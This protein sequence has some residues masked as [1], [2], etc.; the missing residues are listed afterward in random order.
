MSLANFDTALH[1]FA[2]NFDTEY[3]DKAV[4]TRG[5]F[6]CS[7]PLSKLK[8]IA[9]DDYVI[10]KGTASFCA[11]VE[12][13]TKAWANMQGATA[14]KFGIYFGKTKSDPTM[15]YRF[16]Q[17]FGKTEN[18]A[19]DGVKEALLNLVKAGKSKSFR[20]IDENPLSQ[21]FKA[22]IL[23]LYFP[24]IYLNIC[25]SEHLEKIALSIGISEQQFVSEY[26]HLLVENKLANKITKDW[27]NPKFMSFLYAN[28]IRGDLSTPPSAT[29]KNPRKKSRRR[30]NFEDITA[31]R[32]AI[33]KASEE[34]AIE[35]E[36]NRLIG[37]GYQ[38]LVTKIEDRRDIPSY[39]YDYLSFSAPGHER[40]IEVKSVGRDRE[41]ECFRFYLS[42]NELSVSNSDESSS[43]YYFYLVLYGKDGKPCDLL[44]RH[45]KEFYKS[46]EISPC[47]YVVRFDLEDHN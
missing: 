37:L 38:E 8:N 12:V 32:D 42:E 44:A 13:K 27:S 43:D 14:K 34:F 35:W 47:A 29:F 9:L 41:E 2:Q 33:G 1:A 24:E 31:N 4:I 10:G 15:R 16:A 26:Q 19:F 22:K 11:C 23:S 18:E 17:K 46:S 21:M 39:G 45:A 25:S 5:K 7:Y 36:K 3:E 6:L 30:V 20:E 40:Y 28:F